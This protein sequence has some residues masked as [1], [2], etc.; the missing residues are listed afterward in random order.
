M[1]SK[2]K[3]IT[4]S[5]KLNTP[6]KRRGA[7]W[8]VYQVYSTIGTKRYTVP[9]KKSK[10]QTPLNFGKYQAATSR[11]TLIASHFLKEE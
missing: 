9:R 11:Y 2:I 8:L 5:N 3:C 10:T 7:V 4:I 1:Y 6:Y